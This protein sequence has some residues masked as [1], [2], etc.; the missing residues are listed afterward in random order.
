MNAKKILASV[1]A[2]TT[3][4]ALFASGE[5]AEKLK[6]DI[7]KSGKPGVVVQ[8]EDFAGQ[9]VSLINQTYFGN[10]TD[11]EIK[12]LDIATDGAASHIGTKGDSR[13]FF[14]GK[15]SKGKDLYVT[16]AV[17]EKG[18]IYVATKCGWKRVDY[19]A[20]EA[21]ANKPL[22]EKELTWF[23][24]G[25]DRKTIEDDA[26]AKGDKDYPDKLFLPSGVKK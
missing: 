21:D 24:T 18:D 3:S 25:T 4:F 14:D 20:F 11:K 23:L 6:W 1:F 19:P 12:D 7:L 15:D 13:A 26:K 22:D 2:V 17:V 10:L 9:G 5:I 16:A 8:Y